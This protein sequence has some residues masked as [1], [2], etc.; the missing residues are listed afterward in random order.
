MSELRLDV[1]KGLPDNAFEK[2]FMKDC[3]EIIDDFSLP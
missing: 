3:L 2:L 1:S